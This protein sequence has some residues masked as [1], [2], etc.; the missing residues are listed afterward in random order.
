M[1]QLAQS[2]EKVAKAP[3]IAEDASMFAVIYEFEV[4]AG[5]EEEFISQWTRGTELIRAECGSLG[6]RLHREGNGR[7]LAYARWPSR[8]AWKNA[9]SPVGER[10]AALD[11]M[12]ATL[13]SVKVAHELEIVSDR[14]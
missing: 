10:K 9:P 4:L 11:A 3:G 7:Y 12:R 2:H 14:L 5:Q 1:G 8:D 13:A 6:S